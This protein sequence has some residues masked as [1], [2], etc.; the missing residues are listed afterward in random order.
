MTG[1]V[2]QM[3]TEPVLGVPALLIVVALLGL[4]AGVG[5]WRPNAHPMRPEEPTTPQRPSHVPSEEHSPY[6][7]QYLRVM[8]KAWDD[9]VAANEAK[10]G[11]GS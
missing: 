3:A 9:A 6:V 4:I 7:R 2:W 5:L 8:D 11:Q 10:K 1:L